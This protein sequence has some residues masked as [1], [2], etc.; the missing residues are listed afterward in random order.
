MT[1]LLVL[2]GFALLGTLALVLM[3]GR[4][5]A[6]QPSVAPERYAYVVVGTRGIVLYETNDYA[7][8]VKARIYYGGQIDS[9]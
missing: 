9:V 6:A 1:E 8:A 3:L 4:K 2:A 5:P 7:D